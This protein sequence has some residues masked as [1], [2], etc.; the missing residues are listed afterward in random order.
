MA[1]KPLTRLLFAQGGQCFFCKH[2]LPVAD[3]SVEHL[4]ASSNGGPDRDDNCVVCCKEL[5]ALLGCM[6]LKEKIQVVLNQRGQFKCPNGVQAKTGLEGAPKATSV[7]AER[8][9]QVIANLKQRGSAKPRTVAKLKTTIASLFQNKLSAQE[10]D[11]LIQQLQHQRVISIAGSAI[12]Y[13]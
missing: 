1:I 8:Y 11:A 9:A 3:A 13:V 10:L 12:K 7:S 2:P 5:N 4:V 6:S